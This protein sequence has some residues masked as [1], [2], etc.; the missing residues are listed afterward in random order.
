MLLY[1]VQHGKAKTEEEDPERP[2][3][4]EGRREVEAVMVLMLRAGAVTASR[5]LHSGK[6]RAGETANIIGTKLDADTE[7]ADGLGPGDDPQVWATRLRDSNRD[8]V[9]VGHLPH[10]ARLASLLLA[11]DAGA[12][13]VE[14]VNG[15][16]VCLHRNDD[17][18]WG[19][20]WA[21]TPSLVH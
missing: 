16:V 11:G 20:R 18:A 15:G 9:L 12:S 6:L 2:L 13:T 5:V 17:G 14:F 19:L 8:T 10:L 4:D 21:V 3:T 1:L 7:E